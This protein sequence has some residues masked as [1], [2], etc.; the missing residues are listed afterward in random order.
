[1]V[2]GTAG[3]VRALF[4]RPPTPTRWALDAALPLVE[5]PPAQPLPK[6]GPQWPI[7]SRR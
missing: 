7:T 4:G 5:R 2:P 3:R 6:G 1:V